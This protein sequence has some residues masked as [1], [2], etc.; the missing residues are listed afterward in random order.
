MRIQNKYFLVRFTY[1]KTQKKKQNINKKLQ[2]V[3]LEQE[4]QLNQQYHI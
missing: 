1:Q 3:D 2:E 4:Q